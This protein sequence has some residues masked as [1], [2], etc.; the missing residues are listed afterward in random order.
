MKSL[1]EL[2]DHLKFLKAAYDRLNEDPQE[3][4]VIREDMAAH[5]KAVYATCKKASKDLLEANVIIEGLVDDID[6]LHERVAAL[7]EE[8]AAA[9]GQTANLLRLL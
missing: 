3:L 5:F 6:G 7:E 2:N 8:L 1:S 9:Q 4:S